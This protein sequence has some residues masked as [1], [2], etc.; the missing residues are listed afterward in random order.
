MNLSFQDEEFYQKQKKN[1]RTLWQN[2]N[3]VIS[4][5]KDEGTLVL[6]INNALHELFYTSF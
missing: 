6:L 2:N 1:G 5:K 4:I 3:F